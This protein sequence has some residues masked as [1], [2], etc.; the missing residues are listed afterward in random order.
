MRHLRFRLRHRICRGSRSTPA[1]TNAAA[2]DSSG[3]SSHVGFELQGLGHQTLKAGELRFLEPKASCRSNLT[4][5]P[6]SLQVH[7]LMAPPIVACWLDTVPPWQQRGARQGLH[8]LRP[9]RWPCRVSETY[10]PDKRKK[11]RRFT[12]AGELMEGGGKVDS[13]NK[14]CGARVATGRSSGDTALHSRLP[15]TSSLF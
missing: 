1:Q 5:D 8:H 10:G 14:A 4:R 15:L 9:H 3:P 13:L 7:L 6:K 11:V 12:D 2:S